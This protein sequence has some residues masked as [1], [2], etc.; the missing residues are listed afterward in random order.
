[1]ANDL[2]YLID[3][4]GNRTS[5]NTAVQEFIYDYGG[6]DFTDIPIAVNI[7]V[8]VSSFSLI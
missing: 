1:M 7:S 5:E 3:S 6:G 4:D 8:S 2:E